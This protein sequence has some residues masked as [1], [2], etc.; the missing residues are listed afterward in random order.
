[1]DNKFDKAKYEIETTSMTNRKTYS[2]VINNKNTDESTYVMINKEATDNFENKD[3]LEE[4]LRFEK[5]YT[6]IHEKT[7]NSSSNVNIEEQL[8][9]P[10]LAYIIINNEATD[11][12]RSEV[13]LEE[14]LLKSVDQKHSYILVCDTDSSDEESN[15]I[16]STLTLGQTF[17]TWDDAEKFLDSY[18][19]EK[20]FSI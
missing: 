16:F 11:N 18:G 13:N 8:F 9:E 12:S 3:N 6:T 14:Q 15:N 1:M 4:H 2:H 7:T 5:T 19:L 10:E 17:I 20:G